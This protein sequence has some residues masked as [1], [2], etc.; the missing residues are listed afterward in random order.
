MKMAHM[1]AFV[2]VVVGAVNWGLIG[3]MNL[4]VV[5][6]L[7]GPW[8]VIERLVYVLVGLSGLYLAGTHMTDCRMCSMKK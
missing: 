4:N 5:G 8:P 2:L 6:M 7:F 3:L 1:L